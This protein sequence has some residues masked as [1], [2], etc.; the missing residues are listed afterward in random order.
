MTRKNSLEWTPEEYIFYIDG[1]ESWRS[2][3]G[4]VSRVPEYIKITGEISTLTHHI[5][6][7]W[8]GNPAR[9][10]FPDHFL[11]DWVRVYTNI[12]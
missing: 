2:S 5:G 1:M 7:W 9:S 12:E 8:A 11:I 6:D 4:G 3:A 10:V